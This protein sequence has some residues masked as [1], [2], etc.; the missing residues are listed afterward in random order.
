MKKHFLLALTC[1]AV[2]SVN[3]YAAELN[4]NGKTV[5]T[6]IEISND[7][8][9]MPL[10]ALL[11]ALNYNV[12]WDSSTKTVVANSDI[13]LENEGSLANAK[14]IFGLGK[15]NPSENFTGKVYLNSL[16]NNGGVSIANVTFDKGCINK[17][18]IHDHVQ[19]LMGA[20][21]EGYAQIEG[22]DAQLITVGDVVVIPA[23]TKHWHGA[24]KSSQFTHT[25]ISGPLA[26]GMEEFGTEWL[27]P[28]DK[29]NYNS[30]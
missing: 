3:T 10:R 27:E 25:A 1:S 29:D 30:L 4:V 14:P 15:E 20:M 26:E 8:T 7:Q 16:A 5:N 21:G 2:L 22:E 19:I 9:I 6:G 18:H 11:E 12:G 28:V 13:T 24:T 23:G 17:W